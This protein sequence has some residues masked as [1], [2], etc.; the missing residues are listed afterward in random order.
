MPNARNENENLFKRGYM[1][2]EPADKAAHI[3]NASFVTPSWPQGVLVDVPA[4]RKVTGKTHEKIPK[5]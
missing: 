1:P 5:D 3:E 2:A 4:K